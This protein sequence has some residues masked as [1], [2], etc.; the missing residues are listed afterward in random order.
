M[1]GSGKLHIARVLEE[2]LDTPE[3]E[4]PFYQAGAMPIPASYQQQQYTGLSS[5]FPAYLP[6]YPY[7]VW[8]QQPPP[9]LYYDQQPP[10]S[11]CYDQQPPPSPYYD[12]QPPPSPY[13]DPAISDCGPVQPHTTYQSTNLYPVPPPPSNTNMKS[14]ADRNIFSFDTMATQQIQQKYSHH[15]TR[16]N[17]GCCHVCSTPAVQGV[18]PLTGH[19]HHPSYY[20][21]QLQPLTPMTPSL[22]TGYL[23]PSTPTP[24][25]LPPMTPTYYMPHDSNLLHAP[26]SSPA[27]PYM[28][29][30]RAVDVGGLPYT[31]LP[32]SQPYTSLKPS[33]HGTTQ[34]DGS[35]HRQN[36]AYFTSPFKR[37]SKFRGTPTPAHF[38]LRTPPVPQPQVNRGRG[39][40]GDGS[41][42]YQQGDRW[43]QRSGGEVDQ[44]KEEGHAPDLVR[45]CKVQASVE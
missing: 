25:N 30:Q 12:Q 29:Y 39:G 36:V 33:D 22:N 45:D 8:N 37:F 2:N 17:T 9:S 35:N 27:P 11:P 10:P 24:M 1:L 41:N 28:M 6:A 43:G 40:Q 5:S 20:G 7:P 44:E 4:A 3:D 38:P 26:K 31:S 23:L 21:H 19:H 15:P 13:Y 42:W 16:P 34:E 32:P 18:A 14:S